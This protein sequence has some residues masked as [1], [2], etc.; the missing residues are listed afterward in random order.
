MW[1]NFTGRDHDDI[2]AYRTQWQSEVI[3]GGDP[4]G[5]FGQ[6]GG[7]HGSALPAPALPTVRLKPR[8]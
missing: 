4:A 1:W 8:D 5:R 7:W 6:V 3:E 2:V